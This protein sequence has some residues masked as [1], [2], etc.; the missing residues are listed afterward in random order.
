MKVY[1]SFVF[2]LDPNKEQE[3]LFSKHLGAARFAYNW[4]LERV[5]KALSERKIFPTAR[6]LFYEWNRWKK[7]NISWWQEVFQ[8]TIN[9]AFMDLERAIFRWRKGLSG[10]PKFKKKDPR[11]FHKNSA[12]FY[13]PS[14]K[15]FERHIQLPKIGKIRSKEET[16][17]LLSLINEGKARIVSATLS[18]KAYRWYVSLLCEVE[19]KTPSQREGEPVG[20]DLG[21]NPYITLSDG[22]SVE[23]PPSVLKLYQRVNKEHAKLLRK[24][25][26]SKNYL[27]A[28]RKYTRLVQKFYNARD[29]FLHKLS[30]KLVQ[31]YPVLVVEGFN[32]K[33]LAS[34]IYPN[35]DRNF[36]NFVYAP[37]WSK[38]RRMLE[39]KSEWHGGRLIVTPKKF[40]ASKRCSHCGKISDNPLGNPDHLFICHHCG[41]KVD[42]NLNS[43]INLTQYGKF[44]LSFS[45]NEEK[46]RKPRRRV[47]TEKKTS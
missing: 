30:T 29:D 9:A 11:G 25:P 19:M 16:H 46:K 12:R 43:A 4:G 42:R 5:H 38:F 44:S 20:I 26:D 37:G 18:Q 22:T 33:E 6:E 1:R 32:I 31:T 14:I 39:Y 34:Q 23:F 8:M 10:F 2:E 36:R 7:E 3:T 13:G 21:V 35:M 24:K 28:Y 27:K 17:R 40:P 45:L 41:Y 15:V 47:D